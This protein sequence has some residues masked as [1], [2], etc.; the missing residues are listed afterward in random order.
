[1]GKKGGK[2][3]RR[4]LKD[5]LVSG[6][7]L[8]RTIPGVGKIPGIREKKEE[9]W[10]IDA[11]NREN[12]Y[13]QLVA[14]V[15]KKAGVHEDHAKRTV[16]YYVGNMGDIESRA[17]NLDALVKREKDTD[18]LVAKAVP[19]AQVVAKAVGEFEV[20]D[21]ETALGMT[22][23]LDW[24]GKV[25][26]MLGGRADV[27]GPEMEI[28]YSLVKKRH[29]EMVKDGMKPL[30]EGA[31]M[32]AV[33]THIWLVKDRSESK[34]TALNKMTT[35]KGFMN[36]RDMEDQLKEEN[37]W[38][39]REIVKGQVVGYNL[40]PSKPRIIEPKKKKGIKIIPS[41]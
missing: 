28:H 25:A 40:P 31:L 36:Q 29:G 3:G 37:R 16:D 24:A 26:G 32:D 39:G 12:H 23:D 14:T 6:R 35:S 15:A 22:K 17:E 21:A 34:A 30:S 5:V 27:T 1:M 9:P 2:S 10:R 41:D 18:A 13:T 19:V 11:R 20:G 4:G 33:R 7:D 38:S 8:L